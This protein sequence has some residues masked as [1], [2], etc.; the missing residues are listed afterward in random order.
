MPVLTSQPETSRM[1]KGWSDS[2]PKKANSAELKR[3]SGF[4]R[5]RRSAITIEVAVRSIENIASHV[6]RAARSTAC[7]P[8][9]QNFF[10]A[11]SP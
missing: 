2:T 4:A 3:Y 7:H 9:W 11:A 10:V 5:L 6:K 8:I 1:L